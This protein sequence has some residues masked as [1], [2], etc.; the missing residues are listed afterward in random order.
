MFSLEK[1]ES[2]TLIII[3][4]VIMPNLV[5]HVHVQGFDLLQKLPQNSYII[6][7]NF[8]GFVCYGRFMS[9]L[10]EQRFGRLYEY[11]VEKLK[12]S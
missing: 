8:Q 4:L 5:S 9:L 7:F 3:T 2:P 12:E 10:N 1:K 11:D 6:F